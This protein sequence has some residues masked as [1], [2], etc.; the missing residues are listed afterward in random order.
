MT[1]AANDLSHSGR[2][3]SALPATASALAVLGVG[4][5][6]L[7]AYELGSQSAHM[8][9]HIAT[10]NVA[11]PLGAAALAIKLPEFV[12]RP[13]M[14]WIATAAQLVLLWGWHTPAAQHAAAESQ[15][16]QAAMH[17]T[18]LLSSVCFWCA[19][20]RLSADSGWQAIA[21]LL[22]TGKLACLLSALLIFSPRPLYQ[23]A[24]HGMHL[25]DQQ[26]AG[27]LMITA[28]PL[29]YL[30]AAMVIV[31]RLIRRLTETPNNRILSPAG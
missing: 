10:M 14:L 29:S 9:V 1:V 27:L 12:G 6:I 31:V 16:M 21:A 4:A 19:V 26:L 25:D 7:L 30:V 22:L 23:G 24:G 11:A 3:V 2:A 28:C 13:R 5:F 17:I 20:V 15:A 18:L 8:A